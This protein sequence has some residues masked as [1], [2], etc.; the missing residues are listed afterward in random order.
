MSLMSS[1]A[2]PAAAALAILAAVAAVLLLPVTS[3]GA[4][5]P[6]LPDL[7][8]VAPTG[9]V[10]TRGGTSKQPVYRLGFRSAVSNVGAGPLVIVGRRPTAA[11]KTMVADQLV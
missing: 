7:D 10:I 2:R 4:G 9:L 8:Q 6:R 11:S 3:P 5:R 1:A